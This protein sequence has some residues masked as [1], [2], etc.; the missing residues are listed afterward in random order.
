MRDAARQ[1]L[2]DTDL[3]QAMLEVP[4]LYQSP[5]AQKKFADLVVNLAHSSNSKAELEVALALTYAQREYS[6]PNGNHAL[7]WVDARNSGLAPGEALS[8][9]CDIVRAGIMLK[10]LRAY[11]DAAVLLEALCVDLRDSEQHYLLAL[12]LRLLGGAYLLQSRHEIAEETF[13]DCLG[14]LRRYVD[15][16]RAAD[17]RDLLKGEC[18]IPQ[19]KDVAPLLFAGVLNDYAVLRKRTGF[20][21]A[22]TCLPCT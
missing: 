15:I 20:L 3:F 14:V 12:A 19:L 5:D 16:G 21:D 18:S 17:K 11:A 8:V 13:E 22:K 7:D 6:E 2:D 10:G 9:K 1:I 4:Y